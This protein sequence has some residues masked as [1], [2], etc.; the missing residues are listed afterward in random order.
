MGKG[1]AE[2]RSQ[3]LKATIGSATARK[4][5]IMQEHRHSDQF[6]IRS[7]P[8]MLGQLGAVEPRA[9]HMV[10]QPRLRF[11]LCLRLGIPHGVTVG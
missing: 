11:G 9:H 3:N 5:Q 7:K 2:V 8:A 4:A 10:E 6:G 1:T